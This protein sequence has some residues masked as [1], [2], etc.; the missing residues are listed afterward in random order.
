MV[1]V[2][3]WSG[4]VNRIVKINITST[5]AL[6]AVVLPAVAICFPVVCPC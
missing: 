4:C 2:S 6:Q 1:A 5:P 3:S